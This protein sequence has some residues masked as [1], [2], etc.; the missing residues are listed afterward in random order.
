MSDTRT[1]TTTAADGTGVR[2]L[3]GGQGPVILILHPGM[4][5]GTRYQRVAALLS[6]RFPA[7]RL[8]WR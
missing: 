3:A 5:A 6:E 8:H 7:V 4:E 2:A 1:L